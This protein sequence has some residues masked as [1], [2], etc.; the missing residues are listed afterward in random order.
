MKIKNSLSNNQVKEK[1]RK[2]LK[3]SL[4]KDKIKNNLRRN[5]LANQKDKIRK[6]LNNNMVKPKEKIKKNLRSKLA[7]VKIN[8]I[9]KNNLDKMINRMTT[10]SLRQ[11]LNSSTNNSLLYLN[12]INKMKP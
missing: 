1:I 3:S 5:Q 12:M 4:A 11:C 9:L 7:K 6:N 2:N 8:K 10:V